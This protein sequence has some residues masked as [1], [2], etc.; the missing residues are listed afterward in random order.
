MQ[1]LPAVVFITKSI[2]M[3]QLSGLESHPKA[4]Y[5]KGRVAEKETINVRADGFMG[6]N[7]DHSEVCNKYSCLW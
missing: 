6:A 1:N 4:E 2:A 3:R 7:K 5:S